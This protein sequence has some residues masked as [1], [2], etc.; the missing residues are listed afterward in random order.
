MKR[1]RSGF[2]LVELLVVIAIIGVLVALLLPAIQAAREASRRSSC[3]NNIKQIALACTNFESANRYFPPGGPTCVDINTPA[4]PSWLVA[5][6]QYG[7]GSATCYGPNWAVQLFGFIE[8]GSLAR[9]ASQALRNNP[10]DSPK[11]TRTTIGTS[12]AQNWAV[13]AARRP[14]R[15]SAPARAWIQSTR[16]TTTTTTKAPA[17]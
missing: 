1:S 17:A 14:P 8:Q 6:T 16:P 12:S 3:T 13:W 7:G 2:T 10:E 9:F 11:R 4:G 15:S 5:G